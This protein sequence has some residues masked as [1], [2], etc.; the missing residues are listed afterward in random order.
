[1]FTGIIEKTGTLVSK[2]AKGKVVRLR[3]AVEGIQDDMKLGDSLAC[4]G[5]CL[6]VIDFGPDF[7]E[8]DVVDATLKATSLG[9]LVRRRTNF[10]R[11]LRLSDR[12][13]GHMVQGHVDGTGKI[14]RKIK[15]GK[16][17]ELHIKADKKIISELVAK[18]SIAVD[19]ISLTIQ[20]LA[21]DFFVIAIIPHTLQE[22]NMSGL[23]VGDVVNLEV[24]ILSKY[25]RT[26]VQEAMKRNG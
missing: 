2:K 5:V 21:K 20:S 14:I 15:K 18:G 3:F 26:Y 4:N 17:V 24:D 12:L 23:K 16:N 13:G 7:I 10:E 6:T 11:A 1:M 22:T 19:G 25:V 9:K 8:V